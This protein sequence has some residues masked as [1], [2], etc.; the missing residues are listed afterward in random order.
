[1]AFNRAAGGVMGL[2][3]DDLGSVGDEDMAALAMQKAGAEQAKN[4]SVVVNLDNGMFSGRNDGDPTMYIGGNG[5]TVPLAAHEMN[6]G[7]NELAYPVKGG[8]S[9]SQYPTP[10]NLEPVF[11]DYYRRGISNGKY[12]RNTTGY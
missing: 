10:A 1:M 11:A 4:A 3:A 6:M 9:F 12:F 8:G 5:L 2:T 7:R